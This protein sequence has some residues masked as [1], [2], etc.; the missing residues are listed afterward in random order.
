MNTLRPPA[1]GPRWQTDDVGRNIDISIFGNPGDM[2]RR[3]AADLANARS[4]SVAVAFAKQSALR[5]V[6]LDA[7]CGNG[8]KLKLVAGTDFA[9]TEL[10]LVR[11][12]DAHESASCHV[13]NSLGR[14]TFHPKLYV[15]DGGM[16]RVV[17]VTSANLTRGAMRSNVEASVR[18]EGPA[19]AP[20]VV[21][22]TD[23]FRSYFESEFST[24]LTPEFAARYD[25]LQRARQEALRGTR[26]AEE[27]LLGASRM[28]LAQHR[29]TAARQRHL[30]I[31]TPEY[32]KVCVRNGVWGRRK[33]Q[34]IRSYAP[35]DLF[36]FYV[37][38][39]RGVPMIGMFTGP[40]WYDTTP[41]WEDHGGT[42]GFP[43]RIRFEILGKLDSGI[44]A[45]RVLE[46]LRVNPRPG[47]ISGYAAKSRVLPPHEFEAL[48]RAFEDEYRAEIKLPALLP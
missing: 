17:Y 44:D 12:L 41:L 10:D 32:Y 20:Q 48:R 36:F 11:R 19:D 42:P 34:Q 3:F 9:I 37:T 6:D 23:L 15:L 18:L 8:G 13:Y 5:E 2:G 43:W 27:A 33:E 45:R 4:A 31:V 30:L 16:S 38:K 14:Q 21:Q 40:P 7:W 28:L 29:G 47:W 1:P 35:G 46:P 22:A 39:G 24:P 26:G 25:E